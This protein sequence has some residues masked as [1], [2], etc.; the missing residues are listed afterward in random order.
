MTICLGLYHER[1]LRLSVLSAYGYGES[2]TAT[3]SHLNVCLVFHRTEALVGM[4]AGLRVETL[5]VTAV[6]SEPFIGQQGE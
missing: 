3:L 5:A 6:G 4:E 1:R 2:A